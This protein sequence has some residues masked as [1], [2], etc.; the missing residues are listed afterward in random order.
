MRK[1]PGMPP[2]IVPGGPI[3]KRDSYSTNP[4]LTMSSATN[5]A[6]KGKGPKLDALLGLVPFLN[7]FTAKVAAGGALLAGGNML[8]G[9]GAT[10]EAITERDK[11]GGKFDV[12]ILGSAYEAL[13][14]LGIGGGR[15]DM[16]QTGLKGY[17]SD[18]R[19]D[20]IRGSALYGQARGLG[21]EQFSP[22][23][24]ET[25]T[26]Y[27]GRMGPEIRKALA[28]EKYNDPTAMEIRQRG[29]RAEDRDFSLRE[30][31]L[32]LQRMGIQG[33]IA[34]TQLQIQSAADANKERMFYH[35]QDLSEKREND[36]YKTTAG[37]I[38][39]L[40]ALGAAFAL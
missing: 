5:P 30:Q 17:Q 1:I 8:F 9:P 12:G 25:L 40:S 6:M 11:V 38:G 14:E 27:E 35:A 15:F 26:V 7:P 2:R 29:Q 16:S 22:L 18:A 28:R 13:D 39:G 20:E 31:N 21:I 19:A 34:N 10:R 24:N 33:N 23:D 3:V 36:R 4:S 37:L 32:G